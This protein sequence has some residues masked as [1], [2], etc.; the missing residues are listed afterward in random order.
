MHCEQSLYDYICYLN[1]VSMKQRLQ[2]AKSM[3]LL[4]MS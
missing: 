1:A 2:N 4:T 3:K